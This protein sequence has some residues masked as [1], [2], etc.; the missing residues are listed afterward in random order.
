MAASLLQY[1][2]FLHP[3]AIPEELL[4][5]EASAHESTTLVKDLITLHEAMETLRAYSL[6]RRHPESTTL[7]I[8]RLVQNEAV[9]LLRQALKST[10]PQ[11]PHYSHNQR[12]IHCSSAGA[13]TLVIREI[14]FLN[15]P[16]LYLTDLCL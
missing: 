15:I 5:D 1:C 2:A 4:M 9:L 6:V 10:W 8:H 3:D 12:E 7:S 11:P 16:R 13:T 14:V